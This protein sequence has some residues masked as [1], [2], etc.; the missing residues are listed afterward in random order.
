MK[1]TD[2]QIKTTVSHFFAIDSWTVIYLVFRN[3]EML[4]SERINGR[5]EL[6]H[7]HFI[8][9]SVLNVHGYDSYWNNYLTTN[10]QYCCDR[11]LK[12]EEQLFLWFQKTTKQE[13]RR[14][15]KPFKFTR[16]QLVSNGFHAP[17]NSITF[18]LW[19]EGLARKF[20][21][22]LVFC[23]VTKGDLRL[24]QLLFLRWHDK[25]RPTTDFHW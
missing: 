15:K 18:S 13:K 19:M 2:D 12:I 4:L 6:Y 5:M 21:V 11:W 20:D 16:L 10:D 23:A 17:L 22:H 9:P 24:F 25:N 3:Y 14:S 1:L 7:T 8:K